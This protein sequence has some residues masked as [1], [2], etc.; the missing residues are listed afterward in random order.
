MRWA[1]F[2]VMT[3]ANPWTVLGLADGGGQRLPDPPRPAGSSADAPLTAPLL[4]STPAAVAEAVAN[5]TDSDYFFYFSEP[6]RRLPDALRRD[7]EEAAVQQMVV[8]TP[9]AG[10]D[11]Y[12]MNAWMGRPGVIT[13]IHCKHA[14][15]TYTHTL[16]PLSGEC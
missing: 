15:L 7:T 8:L 4:L 11:A 6:V 9:E 16:S 12:Q 2:N 10:D 14:H 1:D 3:R 5:L 13:H